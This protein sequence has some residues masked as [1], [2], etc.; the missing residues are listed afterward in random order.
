MPMRTNDFNAAV[1]SIED[2]DFENTKLSTAKT[3]VGANCLTT[4][5][6]ISICNLFGFEDTKLQF[7]KFAYS[8]TYDKGN[9][10][11]INKV[12]D[13]DASKE[14]LNRFVQNGGR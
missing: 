8:K 4:D 1:Q 13:F 11:K 6:V 9:Y 12:F 7:A 5:Q 3:I 10:F 14:T 2:A